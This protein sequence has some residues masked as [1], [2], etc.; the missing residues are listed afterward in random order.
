MEDESEWIPEEDNYEYIP[1]D[2]MDINLIVKATYTAEEKPQSVRIDATVEMAQ[3]F[4]TSDAFAGI[5]V[6]GNDYEAAG[7]NY[8]SGVANAQDYAHSDN[9]LAHVYLDDVALNYKG[10]AFLN[11]W[12]NYGYFC[13]R[14]GNNEATKITI[15]AGLEIP[16]YKNLSTGVDEVY[17][18]T[19]NITFIKV[20]GAWTNENGVIFA[21]DV[22]IHEATVDGEASE[23]YKVEIV[24]SSWNSTRNP[25]DYNYGGF[26]SLRQNIF[27]NGASVHEI[28]TTVD[29]S[30]YVYSTAPSSNNDGTFEYNG[31][32]YDLFKN[33]VVL[34]GSGDT[35]KLFIH[36]DY[37]E[38]LG[39][40]VEVVVTINVGFAY[41]DKVV[42]E[43][44]SAVVM[45]VGGGDAPV[46]PPVETETTD[47]TS[48]LT[49]INQ[50]E[51]Y[52]GTA[53]YLIRTTN[54]YWT[55]VPQGGCLN[56][57]DFELPGAG[58]EQM[59]YIYFNGTSLAEINAN[60]DGSYGSAQE[61]IANGGRYAP[62]MVF[63]GTDGGD[64]SYIQLY[65][66]N[67]YPSGTA[68]EN[69]K[70]IKI[71]KG[72][73]VT[74]NDV[75]YVV[76][77]DVEWINENGTWTKVG[78]DIGSD[79]DVTINSATVDGEASELYKVEIVS[80]LWNST[81]D[82]FDYN[83][84]AFVSFRQLIFI[85]G[86]SVH[87]INTTVDDSAYVYG[88]SPSKDHDNKFQFEGN[89]YDIFKNP[90]VIYAKGNTITLWIH[91]DYVASLGE[92]VSLI[93][94]LKS[95]F[96][97]AG[98]TLTEDVLGAAIRSQIT[99]K[100]NGED[101][102]VDY[103]FPMEA[104][105]APEKEGTE[106]TKFVFVGWYLEG[107]DEAFD[108]ST[109]IMESI[110]LVAKYEEVERAQYQVTFGNAGPV[111]AYEGW[112]LTAPEAPTQEPTVAEEFVFVGWFVDGDSTKPWDFDN[113]VIEGDVVLV[114]LYTA[115]PRQ[116]TVS[117]GEYANAKTV[118]YGNTVAAPAVTPKKE[119]TEATVYKFIGWF[120]GDE[121][122]DFA[123]DVVEGD[124]TLLPKFEEETRKYTVS[125][126]EYA[127][128]QEVA[129]GDCAE[130]PEA[131]NAPKGKE[132]AGWFY[133]DEEWDFDTEITEDIE[134]E[135]RFV[136]VEDE[137]ED[138]NEGEDE[139]N[140]DN[141]DNND[142]NN[143]NN[144]QVVMGCFGSIGGGIA[145]IMLP[146]AAAIALKKKKKED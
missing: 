120:N 15:L 25:F 137:G 45:T 106:T 143:N 70:S 14:P 4:G 128:S 85:N 55:K 76:T 72:F 79:V 93:V 136:D 43:E 134:L 19:E 108:F 127:D 129:Y 21:E 138:E 112:K 97:F 9:F 87:E 39:A 34:Y 131:P 116:Y 109:P 8:N 100:V 57:Y 75:T 65:I 126:G 104:P 7:D 29:D 121:K 140:N 40:G 36:K 26:V 78:N 139:E 96:N 6:V 123:T 23:L 68:A 83:Y 86:K 118:R 122:W 1:E 24:S 52:T 16:T 44:V 17:V 12:G 125:F 2:L 107:S 98:V 102:S 124:I 38:S 18:I 47:I 115:R 13:F 88:S 64:Y 32:T 73:S 135:A 91:K 10:E 145:A 53:T 105:V 30:A 142:N 77:E 110:E 5:K 89:E 67:A 59:H 119:S 33:P 48:E 114:A 84:A 28:N 111:V 63:M 81:R 144:G 130:E 27:I 95:G 46:E 11:V 90:I 117:F 58:Q 99:I 22:N 35:L 74:E 62:I 20:G 42:G 49:F 133:D 146:V 92:N 101:V 94:E 3:I 141:N 66:P 41:L 132:F 31:V 113:D 69:H 71:A 54:N 61:N 51:Y 82:P 56:E 37:I 80:S 60:D 50:G 103:G